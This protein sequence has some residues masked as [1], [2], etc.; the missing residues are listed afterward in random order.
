[1]PAAAAEIY[2][3]TA[4]SNNAAAPGKRTMQYPAAKRTTVYAVASENVI[5]PCPYDSLAASHTRNRPGY[6]ESFA[7][8]KI[9]ARASRDISDRGYVYRGRNRDCALRRAY[10][11]VE[12]YVYTK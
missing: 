11:N 8:K 2:I 12:N 3:A 10:W 6:P 1:M 4:F 7:S 5:P 9:L